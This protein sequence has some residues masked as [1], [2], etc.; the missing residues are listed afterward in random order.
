MTKEIKADTQEIRT[1][2]TAIKADTAQILAEI[3]RLQQQLPQDP[4]LQNTSGFMLERYLDNLTTYAETVCDSVPD[5]LD[6]FTINLNDSDGEA[7]ES[8]NSGSQRRMD[9]ATQPECPL[10]P[11]ALDHPQA[12]NPPEI[13]EG[14]K[15]QWEDE[16]GTFIYQD[17]YT[18]T[19]VCESCTFKD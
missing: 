4:N 17:I 16:S 14:W 7:T 5:N 15:A 18:S 9:A 3:A 19:F 1:D 12:M 2:T 13:P 8:P 6:T 11:E 10:N